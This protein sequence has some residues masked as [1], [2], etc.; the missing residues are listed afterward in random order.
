MEGKVLAPGDVVT[1]VDQFGKPHNAVVTAYWDY[2][3]NEPGKALN[4][5]YVVD[6]ESKSDSY[7]RQIERATSVSIQSESTAHGRYY[8]V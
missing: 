8:K 1:Y 7:G 3:K 2:G 5:V 4:L 6:D